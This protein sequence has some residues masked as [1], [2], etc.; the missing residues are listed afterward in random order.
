MTRF[1]GRACPNHADSIPEGPPGLTA[2][3]SC[4]EYAC[5]NNRHFEQVLAFDKDWAVDGL[6]GAFSY[7]S[8][9]APWRIDLMGWFRAPVTDSYTFNLTGG[10]SGDTWGLKLAH[11]TLNHTRGETGTLHIHLNG[12]RWYPL[13][14]FYKSEGLSQYPY[15][16]LLF[17]TGGGDYKNASLSSDMLRGVLGDVG[18]ST[19]VK[20]EKVDGY[21]VLVQRVV[22]NDTSEHRPDVTHEVAI[23][24]GQLWASVY[25]GC[26]SAM[27][28]YSCPNAR[29]LKIETW[30]LHTGQWYHISVAFGSNMIAIYVD[31]QLMG[32]IEYENPCWPIY[33]GD[34]VYEQSAPYW[35]LGGQ[36][37]QSAT[38]LD[39]Y[40][41]HGESVA[42]VKPVVKKAFAGQI[43]A[44]ELFNSVDVAWDERCLCTTVNETYLMASY[45]SLVVNPSNIYSVRMENQ[46]GR[47]REWNFCFFTIALPCLLYLDKRGAGSGGGKNSIRFLLMI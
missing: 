26:E 13:H 34:S 11:R 40:T 8:I 46:R 27:S 24:D 19:W 42:G 5:V 31:C 1:F 23:M 20:P 16:K 9:P 37:V 32:L 45:Q 41:A 29:T 7:K 22:R 33:I 15:Y 21:N 6:P 43:Y 10:G 17:S 2:I 47:E 36:P 18:L 28:A 12:G 35:K 44:V 3:Y 14:F 25:C 4:G 30:P 39:F 38:A